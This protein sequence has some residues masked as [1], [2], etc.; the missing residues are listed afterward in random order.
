MIS[1]NDVKDKTLELGYYATD[2]LLYDTYNAL[3]LFSSTDKDSGQDI[4]SICLEGPPG[5]GKTE[6]ANTYTKLSNILFNDVELVEYQC[7]KTTGKAELYEDIDVGAA[8]SGDASKV[9][10]PGKII[11]AIKKVNA[12]KRVVLF[13]D[14]YDKAREE[15]DAFLL[16]FLQSGKINT[17]QHGDLCVKEE[18]KS[19]LQVILC[20]NDMREELSGPLSR[21]IRIIRLDYMEPAIFYKVAQRKLIEE[22]KRPVDAG[23]INLVSLMYESAYNNR[24][25]YDRLPSCSE[26]L[27]AIQDADR[28]LLA[29]AP[30]NVIYNIII[31]NM[32]K[33]PDDIT[34]FES[35]LNKSGGE[36]KL[37]TLVKAMK[38][39]TESKEKLDLNKIIAEK[40]F[41]DENKE[42]V[43]KTQEMQE[44][45]DTYSQKFAKMEQ[46]RKQVIEH[47]IRRVKLSTGKLVSNT[48]VP[49]AIGN[50]RDESKNIKRGYNIFELSVDNWTDVA[51]LTNHSAL[52]ASAINKL[53][54]HAEK[55]GIVIYEN[56]I[57]LQQC[58]DINL[59]V[60]SEMDANNTQLF[61][62]MA[63]TPVIP[64]TFIKDIYAFANFI[65]ECHSGTAYNYSL[66]INALVYSDNNIQSA[67]FTPVEE[68]I[69]HYE[70]ISTESPNPNFLSAFNCNDA[71]KVLEVSKKIMGTA[72]EK[73]HE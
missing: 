6:F 69:Y 64:S 52:N 63:S 3:L 35:S 49:E 40:V 48:N 66:K 47:Q 61:R 24:D 5:A 26:M 33:S 20:K 23:L 27:I 65:S 53:I 29:N 36:N 50:F 14:E 30:Q 38:A 56:G 41:V 10:I 8:V 55:L 34:T 71:D 54:E 57:L 16:Q 15:T 68:N 9:K 2:E 4:Y 60:I 62:I 72:K 39:T 28:V 21:R 11:E 58:G 67:G 46:D 70:D 51:T 44:L 59:I 17:T 73:K 43:T 12:G 1:F 42:L 13:I 45:I 31:K 25:L 18:Y 37:I 22:R 7:D 32:F 19:R